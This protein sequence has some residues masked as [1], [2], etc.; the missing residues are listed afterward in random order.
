MWQYSSRCYV[1][2][3]DGFVDVNI[4]FFG[5]ANYHVDTKDAVITV[6]NTDIKRT[7]NPDAGELTE[8]LN[9]LDGVK[10]TNSIGYDT[11]VEYSIYDDEGNEYSEADAISRAGAYT[12]EYRFKD[13]KSGW[14]K[15]TARLEIIVMSVEKESTQQET[16]EEV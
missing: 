14:I 3:I 12:V 1:S 16:K 5:Y 13:P 6:T 11:E 15:N 10:G 4:A 8:E 7:Y 9:L 2:G